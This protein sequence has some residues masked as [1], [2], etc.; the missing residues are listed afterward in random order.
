MSD[1]QSPLSRLADRTPVSRPDRRKV[2][3]IDSV[4]GLARDLEAHI[5][6]EKQKPVEQRHAVKTIWEMCETAYPEF[7]GKMSY[8]GFWK[9]VVRKFDYHG[10]NPRKD[11]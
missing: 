7:K 9:Y 3:V 4:P 1:E 11:S 6:H 2:S 10:N 5:A 8:N